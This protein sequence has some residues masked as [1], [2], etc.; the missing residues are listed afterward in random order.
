M[1]LSRLSAVQPSIASRLSEELSSASLPQS[2]LFHGPSYSGR[3][4]A[5]IELHRMHTPVLNAPT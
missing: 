3:M 4:S 1:P 2:L 5:A